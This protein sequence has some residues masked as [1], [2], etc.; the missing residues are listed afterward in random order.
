MVC[1]GH[2]TD[3][4]SLKHSVLSGLKIF[5]CTNWGSRVAVACS[6]K[7]CQPSLEMVTRGPAAEEISF[8]LSRGT[9]STCRGSILSLERRGP[10][11]AQ[12]C[13]GRPPSS[14]P[15]QRTKGF[16]QLL[17]VLIYSVRTP[18]LP[19]VIMPGPHQIPRVFLASLYQSC[20]LTSS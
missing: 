14:H 4:T 11:G 20:S 3:G 15:S 8:V 1:E 17:T 2:H 19:L 6:T 10:H 13:Q 16:I 7:Q 12:R 18:V 5:P 9:G